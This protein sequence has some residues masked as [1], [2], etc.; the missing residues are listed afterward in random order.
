MNTRRTCKGGAGLDEIDDP[1]KQATIFQNK[2][3]RQA[4]LLLIYQIK[5][6]SIKIDKIHQTARSHFIIKYTLESAIDFCKNHAI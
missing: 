5:Y 3:M 4:D 6:D 2:L 1:R